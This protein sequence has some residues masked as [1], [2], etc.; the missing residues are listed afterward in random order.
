MRPILVSSCLLG[1]K[2]RYDG[3]DNYCQAVIDYIENNQLI[4]IPVCPEQL[5]GLSTPRPKCW[6]S[7]GDGAAVLT[8]LGELIDEEDCNVTEVFLRGAQECLKIAKLA[9]CELAIMQ[10]RSPSCG[11]QKI[12]L[13][14]ELI[15]GVGVTTALLNKNGLKVF[16]NDN[17]PTKNP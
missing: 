3:T 1:L 2:T 7:R 14:G 9:H 4:P 13:N 5:A 8:G 11:S 10:Q 16:S 15:E 6:F 17:L 12:Y